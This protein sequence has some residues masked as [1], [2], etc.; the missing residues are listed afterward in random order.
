MST[1]MIQKYPFLIRALHRVIAVLIIGM[2][3]FGWYLSELDSKDPLV[4]QLLP[5]HRTIGLLL[6]PLGVAQIVAYLSMA[7]PALAATLKPWERQLAKVVHI[8]LLGVVVVIPAAAYL[9]SGERLVVVG[10]VQLPDLLGL[11]KDTRSFFFEVHE[12]LAYCTAFLAA[13]HAAAALKH[14]FIDK[15]DTLKKML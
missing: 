3:V 2:I 1:M 6:F 12:T 11:S 15:D 9:M 8:L 10:G 7:R 14:H 13:L 4:T 5:W